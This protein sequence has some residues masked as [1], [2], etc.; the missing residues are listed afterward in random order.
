MIANGNY[1]ETYM[2]FEVFKVVTILM[3]FFWVWA[4]CGLA[5][6]SQHFGEAYC[7]HLHPHGAQTQK[8]I[9]NILKLIN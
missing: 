6:R 9:V 3:I 7:L 2:R 1:L 5:G 8:N 4:P